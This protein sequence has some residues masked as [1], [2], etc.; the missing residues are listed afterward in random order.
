MTASFASVVHLFSESDPNQNKQKPIETNRLLITL[1]KGDFM[2]LF[3]Y[4]LII[5]FGVAIDQ[6]TKYT[7]AYYLPIDASADVPVWDGVFSLRCISNDGAAF[8]MLDDKRW[9]FMSV[10]TVVIVG[11]LIFLCMK[12]KMIS[13]PLG[14][15]L[16]LIVSGGVGNMIDRVLLGYVID[17][18]YFVPIDFPCFNVADSL[19]CVGAGLMF[20]SVLFF[21]DMDEKKDKAPQIPQ[22]TPLEEM[23]DGA[24]EVRDKDI[25]SDEE[26]SKAEG[27]ED[28]GNV[29]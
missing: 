17:F 5:V 6:I 16:A 24:L 12:H 10:S 27:T 4:A 22:T 1:V 13:K 2:L 3:I 29:G 19:V 14:I 28:D 20:I 25:S 9:I 15:A 23:T 11:M 26:P 8:G 7:V 21:E 18:I